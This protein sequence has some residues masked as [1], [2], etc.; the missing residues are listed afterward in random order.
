MTMNRNDT[1]YPDGISIIVPTEGRVELTGALLSGLAV[2]REVCT[3]PTEVLV[4]DSS[5]G[6]QREAIAAACARHNGCLVAGP[7]SVR[8]K[9]NLGITSA[10]YAIILFLDS[11]CRPTPD[12]L[13]QHW[14]LYECAGGGEQPGGVLGRVVFEG[15]VGWTWYLV[16]HSS[17]V[18]RFSVATIRP[19]ASW[20]PTA[21]LSLRHSVLDRVGH[22]DT[23]LPFRLGGDDLD[24]TYR[25]VR[26]GFPIVCNPAAIVYHSRSTWSSLRAILSRAFRWGRIE[27]H[28]GRKHPANR[29]PA[30]P[31]FWGWFLLVVLLAVCQTALSGQLYPLCGLPIWWAASL[32]IFPFF[33]AL[34]G[35]GDAVFIRRYVDS[36]ANGVPE[37]TYQFGTTWEHAL[38]LDP[39][40]LWSRVWFDPDD[41]R[42]NWLP[43][44]L[45]TWSNLCALLLAQL[46]VLIHVR[47][48]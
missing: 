29:I 6:Q 36:L 16:R 31:S 21:N 1:I 10:N 47:G 45:N 8:E 41:A 13:F 4:V 26:V 38:H 24:L 11:D 40:F 34:R 22:F 30:P 15:P 14:H 20:G 7:R 28:L 37:L 32:L 2:A 25:V 33:N 46:L 3:F 17:L 39:R 42:R 27:Y 19:T 9:R 12:L 23:Q 43:E 44:A 18:A 35:E 5:S 48:G